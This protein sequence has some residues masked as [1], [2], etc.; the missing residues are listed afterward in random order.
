MLNGFIKEFFGFINNITLDE[1]L[2]SLLA[3]GGVIFLYF[4]ITNSGLDIKIKSSLIK[5]NKKK[6]KKED[7]LTPQQRVFKLTE[8]KNKNNK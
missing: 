1:V 7:N 4:K 8:K 5:K 3:I 6:V 2:Q